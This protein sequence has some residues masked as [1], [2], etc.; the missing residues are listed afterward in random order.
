MICFVWTFIAWKKVLNYVLY[1]N[2]EAKQLLHLAQDTVYHHT[3]CNYIFVTFA[4][5]CIWL[6][7]YIYKWCIVQLYMWIDVFWLFFQNKIR[8]TKAVVVCLFPQQISQKLYQP[9]VRPNCYPSNDRWC[10]V[11]DI[12]TGEPIHIWIH[13]IPWNLQKIHSPNYLSL[14]QY[15]MFG[16]ICF[17]SDR[18]PICASMF[19]SLQT[20]DLFVTFDLYTMISWTKQGCHQH[21]HTRYNYSMS[22]MP[23]C[24]IHIRRS[25][26][27][28]YPW[29]KTK[30]I[31][32]L[33]WTL[34]VLDDDL[35]RWSSIFILT[36]LFSE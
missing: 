9:L 32:S 7:L 29:L 19:V 22:N 28:E 24:N 2:N 12:C 14:L 13:G 11:N 3:E 26:R 1:F 33:C 18:P 5:L 25:S 6:I 17:E 35:D 23:A 8:I 21:T 30:P 16:G 31:K 34:F 15:Q 27:Q 10:A 4:L 20:L 36:C